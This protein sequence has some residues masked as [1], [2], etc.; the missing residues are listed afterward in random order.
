MTHALPHRARILAALLAAGVAA[1]V[2]AR[3][4]HEPALAVVA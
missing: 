2:L 1:A 4:T 3:C